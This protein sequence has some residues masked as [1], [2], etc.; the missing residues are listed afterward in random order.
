MK[1]TKLYVGNETTYCHG[2]QQYNVITQNDDD[3]YYHCYYYVVTS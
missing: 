1:M 2:T 3:D